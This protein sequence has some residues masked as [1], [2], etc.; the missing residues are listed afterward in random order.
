MAIGEA[1][2]LTTASPTENQAITVTLTKPL[3]NPVFA[4]THT[5]NGGDPF[6]VRLTGETLDANGNTTAFTFIIEEWEYLDG[7]HPATETIN[8]LAVEEG[9]HTLPDGRIIEAGTTT[10]DHTN[11]A[12]SLTG[13]FTSPPVVLTSV[14]SNNDSTTVDS[15][16]LNIT[17]SGFNVRLQ[18]EENQD[19]IHADE[20]VGWIAIQPGVGT[21][22][23]SANTFGGVDNNTD[24]LG[25][26]ATFSDGV[27]LG[28]TQT[29]NGGD[30]A[31]LVIDGQ[32]ASTV[33]VYVEEERSRDSET[34]H[35]DETVGIVAFEAGLIA[36]FTDGT[37]IETPDGPRKIET[38]KTGDL[39]TE[40]L[41]AS[42]PVL[43]VY[44]R[45]LGPR[46]LAAN[47]KLRPVRVLQ[48]A[49]NG[50]LPT[51]DLLVSRQHRMLVSSRIAQRMFGCA[52]VLL[53]AIKLTQLPGIFVDESVREVIY[54]HL[55]LDAHRVIYAEGAPTESFFLGAGS[56][57]SLTD[58]ALEEIVMLFPQCLQNPPARMIPDNSQQNRLIGRHKKNH[59]YL[60]SR[61]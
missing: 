37:R 11:T 52:E 12:V 56:A 40:H 61:R 60:V 41:G 23:G 54:H 22:S 17:A 32:T 43:R 10:A 19:R 8:W 21:G 18:E 50:Q 53:P 57:A 47:P 25:L 7:P 30:T 13:G 16:P 33:G 55:L 44:R 5:S 6:V 46:A 26:G 58:E 35:V 49:L 38:L 4:F 14:S 20:T 28:E 51:R 36:C 45:H 24:V 15:D 3:I 29:I 59:Q 31:N 27:V 39:V 2:S 1:G 9:V 48:G 34:N 42:A